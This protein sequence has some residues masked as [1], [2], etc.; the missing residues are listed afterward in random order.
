MTDYPV[1]E[2]YQHLL[3]NKIV[4]EDYDSEVKR[5]R[6]LFIQRFEQVMGY[7]PEISDG[8]IQEHFPNY[9]TYYKVGG[10]WLTSDEQHGTPSLMLKGVSLRINSPAEFINYLKDYQ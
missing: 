1:N 5:K 6:Q 3:F 8:D 9:C 10:Y 7:K 4:R 2:E